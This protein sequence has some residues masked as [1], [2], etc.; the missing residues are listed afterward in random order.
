ASAVRERRIR[1]H[2]VA[3]RM[4]ADRQ[5]ADE[6]IVEELLR[7]LPQPRAH[8]SVH[9]Q[10]DR[11]LALS[12]QQPQIVPAGEVARAAPCVREPLQERLEQET[13][14][15]RLHGRAP[16]PREPPGAAARPVHPG[17][18]AVV[19]L[20]RARDDGEELVASRRKAADPLQRI[21]GQGLLRRELPL[22][23][24]P[25]HG[26]AAPALAAGPGRSH[27]PSAPPPPPPPPPPP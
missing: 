20:A 16:G 15:D 11:A 18:A 10:V 25:L 2:R 5:A 26:A 8:G 17:A 27:A 21:G 13:R 19:E 3:Y 9:A 4:A 12:H 1:D 24:P 22:L 14:L 7:A 23:G 6:P